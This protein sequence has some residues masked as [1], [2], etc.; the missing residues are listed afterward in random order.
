MEHRP[1]EDPGVA[2]LSHD[3]VDQEGS[4]RLDDFEKVASEGAA[5]AAFGGNDPGHGGRSLRS[6]AKDPEV[7]EGAAKILRRY[8]RQFLGAVVLGH[9]LAEGLGSCAVRILR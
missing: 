8:A 1:H 6:L 7:G 2:Q 5:P 4:V 9:P 3:A